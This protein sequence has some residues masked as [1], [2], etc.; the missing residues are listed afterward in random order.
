MTVFSASKRSA[1]VVPYP[2]AAVWEVLSNAGQVAKLTPMVR[3]IEDHG[4]TWVWTLA[5]IQVLGKK[6]G[7]CFTERME[8]EPKT[9]IEYTHAPQGQERAGVEGTY[10]LSD[11][12]SG[13]RLSIQ[14]GV[15]VDLPFPK[16]AR[17]AVQ[18]SMHGV[19][20]AMGAGFAHNLDRHLRAVRA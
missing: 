6:I 13:T 11:T 10:R 17:P 4:H 9:R 3:S 5:P 2:R 15:H 12:G 18:A 19:L 20:A 7:L 1:A 14:L 16:L 8:L